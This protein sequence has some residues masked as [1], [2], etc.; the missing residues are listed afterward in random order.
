ML[1]AVHP[2]SKHWEILPREWMWVN[3][4]LINA[5]HK[6][7]DS[8]FPKISVDTKTFFFVLSQLSLW[9]EVYD[10]T[11]R[12]GLEA[13]WGGFQLLSLRLPGQQTGPAVCQGVSYVYSLMS[14]RLSHLGERGVSLSF[15]SYLFRPIIS[16]EA[17]ICQGVIGEH[18]V[19]L[20]CK[21]K[22]CQL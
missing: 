7:G 1:S 20:N 15:T 19:L 3:Y 21:K 10:Q 4:M 5:M 11:P 12:W 17:G 14:Q 22:N 8:L 13:F 9:K 6:Y 2:G 16:L 18:N